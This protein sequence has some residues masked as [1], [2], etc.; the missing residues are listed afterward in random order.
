MKILK[1][2]FLPFWPKLEKNVALPFSKCDISS[3]TCLRFLCDGFLLKMI[4]SSNNSC[5]KLNLFFTHWN[6]NFDNISSIKV[7]SSLSKLDHFDLSMA[8]CQFSETLAPVE[9]IDLGAKKVYHRKMMDNSIFSWQWSKN[10]QESY[11]CSV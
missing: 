9:M 10:C 1:I 8:D 11:F 5:G 3:Y 2:S 7:V 4:I 6:N